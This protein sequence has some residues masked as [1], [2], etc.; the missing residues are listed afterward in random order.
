MKLRALGLTAL[1]LLLAAGFGG[2]MLAGYAASGRVAEGLIFRAIAVLAFAVGGTTLL[3]VGVL[4]EQAAELMHPSGRR[5]RLTSLLM[6]QVLGQAA[7]LGASGAL[8]LLS[9]LLAARPLYQYATTAHIHAHWSQLAAAGLCL[10]LGI[11]AF[12]LGALGRLLSHLLIRQR[13]GQNH[14]SENTAGR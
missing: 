4:G 10:L 2:S 7:L 9:A 5:S 13:A 12:A 3:S 8:L 14:G 6:G 1:L 11:Q